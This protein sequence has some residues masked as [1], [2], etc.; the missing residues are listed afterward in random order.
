V[1]DEGEKLYASGEQ[2]NSAQPHSNLT[3]TVSWEFLLFFHGNMYCAIIATTF[4]ICLSSN[5][6]I[7]DRN[8]YN[9]PE[10]CM[11]QKG[12]IKVLISHSTDPSGFGLQDMLLYRLLA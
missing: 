6:H 12:N 4:I 11:A 2:K 3:T 8:N 9:K 7:V 5:K 1:R 10:G